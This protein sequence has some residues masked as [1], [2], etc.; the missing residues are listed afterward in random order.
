MGSAV[1]ESKSGHKDSTIASTK[2][3]V[4]DTSSRPEKVMG[5]DELESKHILA[6]FDGAQGASG[7]EEGEWE[8]QGAYPLVNCSAIQT[9]FSGSGRVLS[10]SKV[11]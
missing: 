7:K 3:D 2:G 9:S 6:F 4:A 5:V 1:L 10:Q 11:D 8:E